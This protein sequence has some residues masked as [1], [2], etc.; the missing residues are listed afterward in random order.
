MHFSMKSIK[1][2]NVSCFKVNKAQNS[3]NRFQ[4]ILRRLQ[5]IKQLNKHKIVNYEI[6][7]NLASGLLKT[8]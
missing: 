6:S 4:L 8:W 5:I 7:E 3:I 2:L 1:L